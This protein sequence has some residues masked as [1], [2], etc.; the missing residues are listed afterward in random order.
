MPNFTRLRYF[1]GQMLV[2]NDLQTEQDYFREKLKLL[3]RCL[4][5]YGTVCGLEVVHVKEDEECET[6]D[7]DPKQQS[8]SQYDKQDEESEEMAQQ[9]ARVGS[10]PEG[11]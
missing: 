9:S 8:G 5:G 11:L 2:A 1:H 10:R 7:Y 6:G 4:E 3:N